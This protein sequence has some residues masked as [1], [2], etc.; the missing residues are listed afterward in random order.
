M[1]IGFDAKRAFF[2]AT[3]LG[4]YSRSLLHALFLHHPEAEYLLYS[5]K[6][7]RGSFPD[8]EK[9]AA[10]CSTLRT[11]VS[12]FARRFP[13]L[14]RS[15]GLADAL[16][17]DR[18]DLFHGLSHEIPSGLARGKVKSVVTVHD[19]ISLKYPEFYPWID[20]RI[21]YAKLK[22][23]CANADCV[24]TD[25]RQ[26]ME[27]VR[28]YFKVP[29]ERMRVVPLSC[30]P[31]FEK[32]TDEAEKKR[33]REKHG[34][35]RR[36]L[37]TVGSIN[38]RKNLL[39]LVKA[40]E[41]LDPEEP[42]S[43]V[44]I[45][46][47]GAYKRRVESYVREHRLAGKV[48]FPS[49]VATEDLPAIYQ[50]ALAFAYPSFYEGFGLPIVEAL[51][52]RVPVITSK[53]SCFSEAGGPA[54]LYVDPNDAGELCGALNRVLSDPALRA[55][56]AEKGAEYAGRFSAQALADSTWA[57]YRELTSAQGPA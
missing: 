1:R 17:S 44:A 39:T 35:P 10:A 19:L 33:V 2:N 13:S 15:F 14:W 28:R 49:S 45:G 36:F 30:D 57:V 32:R 54:S 27:D 55:I 23:A 11:P 5:P 29:E 16:N 4:N 47:G 48:L 22:Y 8:F 38:E 6:P 20:R 26:T 25:S 53:G 18:I 37:L 31:L 3:G 42:V 43:L 7:G 12:F 52:S 9:A 41:R 50:A 21:Y 24:I 46:R 56:M 34:L 40:F 51:K